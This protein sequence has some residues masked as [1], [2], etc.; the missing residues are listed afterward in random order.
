MVLPTE[1][2]C[3]S[4]AIANFLSHGFESKCAFVQ[5]VCA[6]QTST[7]NFFNMYYC[8][9]SEFTP[10]FLIFAV[11]FILASFYLISNAAEDYLEPALSVIAEKLK[12]SE[13][14]AG[15]TLVALAN[16]APD[17]F[18]AI[19]AGGLKDEGIVAP[20]GGLLGGGIFTITVVLAVCILAA[21]KGIVQTDKWAM[22]R[23]SILYWCSVLYLLVLGIYG[24]ISA[25]GI[26]GFFGIYSLF[27]GFALYN[28]TMLKKQ[29]MAQRAL[30]DEEDDEAETSIIINY[31]KDEEYSEY[32]ASVTNGLNKFIQIE[33]VAGK[34]EEKEGSQN[35][36]TKP[37]RS[38]ASSRYG[39]HSSF[40]KFQWHY[41]VMK[42]KLRVEIKQVENQT[43]LNKFFSVVNL[44]YKIIAD[45]TIPAISSSNWNKSR[46][47]VQP[48]TVSMF[49]IWQLDLMS[50]F[51]SF[52]SVLFYLGICTI[53]AI[54]VWKT[55]HTSTRPQGLLGFMLLI[56]AFMSSALWINL[57]AHVIVDF[58][59]LL[60][61]FSGLPMN[62][63]GLTLLAWG[64]SLPDL[65]VDLALVK[66]GLDQTALSGIF[67]G[68]FFNFV[69]GYGISLVKQIW[70]FGTRKFA[71]LE[72]T[73]S[74]QVNLALI[75][76]LLFILAGIFITGTKNQFIYNRSF[77]VSLLAMYTLFLVA[78]TLMSI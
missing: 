66:K 40:S 57:I 18:A 38:P 73:I 77:A 19:A 11:V 9:L 36:K 23:D 2:E 47:I 42:K 60:S 74:A 32:G 52:K 31:G 22:S 59:C 67:G 48:F 21:K 37:R 78:V 4:T 58:I 70:M 6:D 26:L 30:E 49:F 76:C 29:E 24:E 61:V 54:L 56:I 8:T 17:V 25:A 44:V 45:L 5:D 34:D 72:G 71:L 7:V 20:L 64:N 65:Y 43:V 55:T 12:M 51:A 69:I 16:G 68:Q 62:Y 41:Y 14:L 63:L 35:P 39:S 28:E 33:Y 13:S 3:T 50:I 75:M 1:L 46:T 15:V 10:I 27:M 53:C